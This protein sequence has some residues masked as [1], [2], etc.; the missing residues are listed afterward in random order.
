[1]TAIEQFESVPRKFSRNLEARTPL[2]YNTA[3][4]LVRNSVQCI[5]YGTNVVLSILICATKPEA[6][7]PLTY[8]T[9]SLH[10]NMHD[11]ELPAD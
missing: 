10:A 11:T 9:A 1:M 2:T 8:N 3:N 6:G 7:T 4:L 5:T